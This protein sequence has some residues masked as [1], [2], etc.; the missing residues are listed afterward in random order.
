M[1]LHRDLLDQARHLA[2]REPKKPKQASLRRAVS[3]AYYALFHLLVNA[4]SNQ[5]GPSKPSGLRP[6]ISRAFVHGHMKSLCKAVASRTAPDRF[7][8]LLLS[9]SA[10]LRSIA[11]TFMDL[12]DARHRADYD[13][14]TLFVRTDTLDLIDRA[15]T[16]FKDWESIRYSEEVRV[17]LVALLLNNR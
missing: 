8:P 10:S 11:S 12:Q 15:E 9:P 14:L 1:S 2:M 7:R 13:L 5:L 6:L 17:F 3:A 4:A 16:A